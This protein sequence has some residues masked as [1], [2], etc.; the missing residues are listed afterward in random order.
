VND[1]HSTSNLVSSSLMPSDLPA[2]FFTIDGDVYTATP[3]TRGPW[4]AVHQHGGPP[5]ALLTRAIERTFDESVRIARLT[6]AFHKPVAITAYRV[7]VETIRDGKKV[8][9]AR[10]HLIAAEDPTATGQLAS[11]QKPV[12][13]A[14]AL[15][16]RRAPIVAEGPAA[17]IPDD[18]MPRPDACAPFAFPFFTDAIGYQ[19]AMEA[20]LMFGRFGEG[21]MGLWMRMRIP[22]VPGETPSP[23]QRVACAADSGN[24]VSVGIDIGRFTFLNPDLTIT[25]ARQAA[26]EW[27]G[28]DGR[29]MF[30][31]DGIGLAE[32]RLLDERGPIGRGMQPLLLEQR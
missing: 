2:S 24:G 9:V 29:T 21:H 10:A 26:G 15:L 13:S 17:S 16:V 30:G 4:T 5:A 7:K 31:D 23:A 22:L 1:A 32:A 27:V 25:L 6:V 18:G 11:E 14:E 28:I 20:R 19:M 3:A 8:K 12:V